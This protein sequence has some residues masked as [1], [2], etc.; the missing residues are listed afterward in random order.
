MDKE[1]L[2][3][4]QILGYSLITII[5]IALIGSMIMYYTFDPNVS[6]KLIPQCSDGLDNDND[7][8]IDYPADTNCKDREDNMEGEPS[9]ALLLIFG[10]IG[11]G[12]I[13]W[14]FI[15]RLTKSV[16]EDDG[17]EIFFKPIHPKRAYDLAISYFLKYHWTDIPAN[18]EIENDDYKRYYPQNPNLIKLTHQ[19][20]DVGTKS[21]KKFQRYF[22]E[23][24]SGKYAD[25]YTFTLP[26]EE[27]ENH[28]KLGVDTF[29]SGVW[30]GGNA[31]NFR[32]KANT[33]RMD[34]FEDNKNRLIMAGIE[35]SKEGDYDKLEEI[36]SLS[37]LFSNQQSPIMGNDELDDEERK[38]AMKERI[39]LENA[40]ADKRKLGKKKNSSSNTSTVDY[41]N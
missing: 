4:K 37:K 2:K 34:G 31:T 32:K 28:L 17:E 27:G 7:G 18:F 39:A 24:L 11:G 26:L 15:K 29:E 21:G 9:K 5:I 35:A 6:D 36:Q 8:F 14:Y 33:F 3:I 13:V 12:L 40:I 19:Y 25:T 1:K 30:M 10:L 23:V 22:I 41:N 20:R 38:E 16:E